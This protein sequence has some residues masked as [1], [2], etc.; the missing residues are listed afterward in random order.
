MITSND[1]ADELNV[2]WA[3]MVRTITANHLPVECEVTSGEYALSPAVAD[4]IRQLWAGHRKSQAHAAERGWPVRVPE[5]LRP[6]TALD[7]VLAAQYPDA[8]VVRP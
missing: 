8:Y 7:D 6:W 2:D 3:R 4:R 1:L 5:S